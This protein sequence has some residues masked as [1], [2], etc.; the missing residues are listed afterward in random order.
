MTPHASPSLHGYWPHFA[1][2]V[3]LPSI[4]MPSSLVVGSDTPCQMPV[5]LEAPFPAWAL[6][7]HAGPS[8][9]TWTLWTSTLDRSLA[10]HVDGF[11]SYFGSEPLSQVSGHCSQWFQTFTP[12]HLLTT[13]IRPASSRHGCPCHH[14]QALPL[15]ARLPFCTDVLLFLFGF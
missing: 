2:A 13:C 10:L 15:H 6:I 5:F 12:G 4:E 8:P 7:P 11:P 3:Q 1:F 9:T 14:T